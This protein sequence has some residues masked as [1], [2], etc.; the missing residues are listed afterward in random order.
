MNQELS[1]DADFYSCPKKPKARVSQNNG[2]LQL[3]AQ[4]HKTVQAQG[5]K[6]MRE[7]LKYF[8]C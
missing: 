2:T 1:L 4:E 3:F 6:N 5:I 8:P 7:D